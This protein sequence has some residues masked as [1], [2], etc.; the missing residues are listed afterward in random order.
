MTD[1][2]AYLPAIAAADYEAFREIM[3]DNIC[4]S[5]QQWLQ[6]HTNRIEHYRGQ[7]GGFVEVYIK[8]DEFETY[9]LTKG[10][11]K[12][13]GSLQRLAMEIGKRKK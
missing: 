13:F 10:C 4:P 1:E 5:F 6:G 2:P 9:C 11:A 8:P 7:D 12:D 3:K